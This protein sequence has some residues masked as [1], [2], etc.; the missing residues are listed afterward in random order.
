MHRLGL[1]LVTTGAFIPVVLV[2][3]TNGYQRHAGLLGN[4]QSM[5][6]DVFPAKYEPH[7]EEIEVGK[8]AD[9]FGGFVDVSSSGE[10]L[11][12]RA[13]DERSDLGDYAALLPA[14]S[15]K[16]RLFTN[17]HSEADVAKALKAAKTQVEHKSGKYLR[18]DGW[19]VSRQSVR[20]SFSWVL[21]ASLGIGFI[22]V[23]LLLLSFNRNP[24][25][26]I[27]NWKRNDFSPNENPERRKEAEL[28]TLHD[29]QKPIQQLLC[30][31]H[32]EALGGTQTGATK[33]MVA[34]LAVTAYEQRRTNFWLIVLTVALVV[35]T[36]VLILLAL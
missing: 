4:I 8:Y 5:T 31:T 23:V 13:T 29:L 2:P 18:Y 28:E 10:I 26:K 27:T 14:G 16:T 11:Q 36:F 35:G 25:Q 6:L 19:T 21:A 33:R 12:N 17:G 9:L 20:V 15:T 32:E 3:L 1:L 30:D 22:G 34:L 7:F 24:L